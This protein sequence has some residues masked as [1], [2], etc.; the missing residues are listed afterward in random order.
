M[1]LT[2]PMISVKLIGGEGLFERLD[3]GDAA[4]D[5]AFEAEVQ[6]AVFG[7]VQQIVA[8]LRH[9]FFVGGD[10]VFAG[11][12]GPQDIIMRRLDAADQFAEDVDVGVVDDIFGP[13]GQQRR[14][15]RHVARLVYVAHGDPF[16]DDGHADFAGDALGVFRQHAHGSAADHAQPQNADIDLFLARH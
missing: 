5:T 12:D 8:G 9:H 14:V 4:A 3:D 15:N 2:M 7:F 1:P 16:D 6:I 11:F 13:I 10:D